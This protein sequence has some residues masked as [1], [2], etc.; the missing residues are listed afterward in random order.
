[1][2]PNDAKL[3]ISP[4]ADNYDDYQTKC[5]NY[6][7]A[8]KDV[9]PSA[10]FAV[11]DAR[12]NKKVKHL[13]TV[14]VLRKIVRTAH[15]S[16]YNGEK[17]LTIVDKDVAKVA[18]VTVSPNKSASSLQV[19]RLSAPSLKCYTDVTFVGS[20]EDGTFQIETIENGALSGIFF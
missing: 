10:S 17:Y 4:N 16:F 14:L 3:V 8:I 11:S 20:E 5:N 18:A 1:M 15:A 7:A 9:L 19:M 13:L 12:A 6:Y 2:N